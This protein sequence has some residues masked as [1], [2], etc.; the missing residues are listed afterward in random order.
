M[1]PT[2]PGCPIVHLAWAS[3]SSPDLAVIDSV[4]RVFI[5]TFS[6]TLNRSYV[7][8]KWDND[9]ADDLNAVVGCYWLP[10]FQQVKAGWHVVYSPAVRTGDRKTYDYK[11]T[12]V[13]CPKP[14][15]PNQ[16]KS[17]LVCVT[18]NGFLKLFFSQNNN[19]M[20]ESTIELDN[21]TSSDDLITHASLISDREL[22]DPQGGF[23]HIALATASKQ[24][25]VVRVEIDWGTPQ[26]DKNK[27][28]PIGV[29]NPTMRVTQVATTCWFEYGSSPS[30]LDTSITQLSLIEFL[31]LVPKPSFVVGPMQA[32]QW[33]QPLI[34]TVRSYVAG[35]NSP[36]NHEQESIVDRWE[37]QERQQKLHPV[38]EQLGH[39]P[40][41]PL[42]S[43]TRL[44]KLEPLVFP[45]VVVSMHVLE[46]GHVLC[47]VFGDGSIQYRDRHT[48]D[49]MYTEPDLN[50]VRCPAGAGFQFT[51]ET[52]CLQT[53]FSPTGCSFVQ[54]CEDDKVKWNCPKYPIEDVGSSMEDCASYFGPL[55]Q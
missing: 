51:E 23:L 24:L 26:P 31:P 49:E 22:T 34:L 43:A 37:L 28:V 46:L 27:Q 38:F 54:I 18:T 35:Q 40:G 53:A 14:F 13:P 15:H 2:L 3:T 16:G 36:F 55:D 5:L 11:T 1:S 30:R 41:N 7:A 50:S 42:P 20:E 45:K 4:G 17:A 19:R 8:R 33:S 52:P 10:T 47:F 6:I 9:A 12:V 44:R 25:K 48:M 32:N 21:V 39:G 29:L